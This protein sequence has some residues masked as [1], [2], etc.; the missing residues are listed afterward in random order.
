[1]NPDPQTPSGQKCPSRDQSQKKF[2]EV[3]S[4]SGHESVEEDSP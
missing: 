3:L 4:L 2:S 1:M